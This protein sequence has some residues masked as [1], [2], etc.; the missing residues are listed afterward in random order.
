MKINVEKN[1]FLRLRLSEYEKVTL[2]SGKI[3][4]VDSS[5]YL[6]WMN[7]KDGGC[8]EDVKSRIA[9][10][11]CFI[12]FS[13]LKKVWKISRYVC[14]PGLGY[15]NLRSWQR[16]RLVLKHGH[17]KKTGKI[18]KMF[19]REIAYG[20]FWVPDWLTVFQTVGCMKSSIQS[21]FLGL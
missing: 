15:W 2:G 13:Q 16:S 1:K 8:S 14:E 18:S 11:R 19:S 7:S 10:T 17:S 12:F 4:Q 21:R 9:K 3:D 6:G 20:M 5:T